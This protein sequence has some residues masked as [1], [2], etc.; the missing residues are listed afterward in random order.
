[1]TLWIWNTLVPFEYRL[2]RYTGFMVTSGGHNRL[3]KDEG[4][5]QNN[6]KPKSQHLNVKLTHE[7]SYW[8]DAL[9][10]MLALS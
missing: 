7:I 1:M 8:T 6:P 4:V 3:I 9:N 5:S 10:L 2:T